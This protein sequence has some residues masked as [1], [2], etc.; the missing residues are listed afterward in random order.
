MKDNEII[1]IIKEFERDFKSY[2]DSGR[3]LVKQLALNLN[4]A[5]GIEKKSFIDFFLREIGSN[6]NGL[7][8]LCLQVIVEA[9]QV[10]VAPE[11]ERVYYLNFET[12]DEKWK[13]DIVMAM[14]QLNYNKPYEL[15][16]SFI[17]Y[18]LKNETG[19]AFFLMVQYC[20]V[21]FLR[22]SELLSN[23]Y[24]NNLLSKDSREYNN[25]H[26]IGYL[27]HW[28]INSPNDCLSGIIKQ[29]GAKNKVAGNYLKQK[30]L[31]FL[32]SGQSS[33][34]K[35]GQVKESIRTINEFTI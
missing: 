25:Q 32:S 17:D 33:D 34:L 31:S 9:N 14:L 29:T 3:A 21:D 22:G 35:L 26:H 18:H 24:A 11:L 20:R 4:R 7:W 1:D 23:Y 19:R 6:K 15:Y 5:E 30:T 27:I 2:K 28:L 12:K 8:A 16:N 13:E 10:T